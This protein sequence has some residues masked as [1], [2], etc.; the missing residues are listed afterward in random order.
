[1]LDDQAKPAYRR[2]LSELREELEEAK[3]LGKRRSQAVAKS[4]KSV[5]DR[6]AQSDAALGDVLSRCIKTG[7]FCSYQPV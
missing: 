1:M 2:R 7:T 5:L 6:I 4:I 3:E